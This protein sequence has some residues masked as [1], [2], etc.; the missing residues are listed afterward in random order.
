MAV[1]PLFRAGSNDGM[2]GSAGGLVVVGPDVAVGAERGL[3]AGVA[4]MRLDGLDIRA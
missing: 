2:D 3:R 4:E 1:P